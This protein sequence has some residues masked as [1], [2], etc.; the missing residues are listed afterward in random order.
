MNL[1]ILALS[2]LFG[3]ILLCGVEAAAQNSNFSISLALGAGNSGFSQDNQNKDGLKRI[4]YP[5]G[6][7]QVQ[8]RINTKWAINIYPNVGLSGNR[9][10]LDIPV[11][12]ITEVRSTSAFLNLGIHPKYYLRKSVYLSLGPEISYL[13]WNNASTYAGDDRQSNIRETE[14]FNRT[15]LLVSSAVGI[16]KKIGESRKDAPLQIDAW[17]FLEFR[18]KYG[19]TNIL[20]DDFFG[21]SLSSTISSFEIVTGISFASKK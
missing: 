2:L 7:L 11:G 20:N 14:L 8:K 13:L 3:P 4:F 5:T 17:W 1:N 18:A 9:R 10:M 19:V 21:A 12:N 6:G 15:N 16:V